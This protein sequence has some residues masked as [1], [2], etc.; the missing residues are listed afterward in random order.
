MLMFILII[1]DII[2]NTIKLFIGFIIFSDIF[3][4][5]YRVEFRLE[6]SNM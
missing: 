3:Y 6:L 1:S 4:G 2:T 5:K